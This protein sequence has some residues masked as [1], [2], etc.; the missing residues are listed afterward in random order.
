MDLVLPLIAEQFQNKGGGETSVFTNLTV[1]SEGNVAE[2]DFPACQV[3]VPAPPTECVVKLPPYPSVSCR[4]IP[5]G[6]C[7]QLAV[8][9]ETE[10]TSY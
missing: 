9:V 3:K 5:T 7:L 1:E 6:E 2:T 8:G 4:I 10:E